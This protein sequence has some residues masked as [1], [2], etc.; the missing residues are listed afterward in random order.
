MDGGNGAGW[1]QPAGPDTG[2]QPLWKVS[3]PIGEGTQVVTGLLLLIVIGL[4][5]LPS[6]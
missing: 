2:G 4:L 5:G 3:A 6:G 1:W